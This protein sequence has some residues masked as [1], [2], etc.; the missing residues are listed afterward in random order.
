[1]K[2]I[3]PSANIWQEKKKRLEALCLGQKQV[4]DLS[5]FQE[6][7]GLGP[8]VGLKLILQGKEE[9]EKEKQFFT[10]VLP[11]IAKRAL[12]FEELFPKGIPVLVPGKNTLLQLTRKQV[13][14]ILSHQFFCTFDTVPRHDGAVFASLFHS[15][16][17]WEV[18]K[19]AMFVNYFRRIKDD[20]EGPPGTMFFRRMNFSPEFDWENCQKPLCEVHVTEPLVPLDEAHGCLQVDFANKYIGGGVLS[21]G[22][23]QEEI[24]FSVCPELTAS[25]V[26][27]P[28]M[29]NNEAVLLTGAEQF[30]NWSGYGFGLR[31]AGDC[32]S[33]IPFNKEL[34]CF[35]NP[36]VAIDAINFRGSANP[37]AQLK[38]NIFL[39]ELTKAAAGM[40]DVA[41]LHTQKEGEAAFL[42]EGVVE[43][44]VEKFKVIATGNWGC[45][46]F[47]GHL[48]VKAVVQ[49]LAAS[50]TEG[51]SMRY[52]PFDQTDL[53]ERLKSFVQRLREMRTTVAQLY[54]AV[55]RLDAFLEELET[56]NPDYYNQFSSPKSRKEDTVFE[57]LLEECQKQATV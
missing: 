19:L 6:L 12:Q 9:T 24:R 27:T 5:T 17:L 20:L 7:L 33:E 22:C 48:E 49:W 29:Q 28:V 47:R 15:S 54:K 8:V 38:R 11:S 18:S 10:E 32:F 35:D 55:H 43:C 46:V 53:A 30:S 52:Y 36:L 2:Y 1:M 37:C 23:V 31:F 13:A 34:N 16:C 3:F 45:G 50:I 4:S 41:L 26:F 51:R 42:P 25:L 57:K 21:G 39:R 40:Q 44:P 56:S 14:C